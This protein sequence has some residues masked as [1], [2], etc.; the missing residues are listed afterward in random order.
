MPLCNAYSMVVKGLGILIKGFFC[1][2]TSAIF[3]SMS[4]IISVMV[5]K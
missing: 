5:G 1:H 2:L 3:L 4:D